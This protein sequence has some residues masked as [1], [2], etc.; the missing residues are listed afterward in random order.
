MD[1]T[2]NTVVQS[3][4]TAASVADDMGNLTNS[5]VEW[6]RLSGEC[7]DLSQ[8]IKERRTKLKA[9]EA[10]I[11]R[12][13]KTHQLGTLELKASKGCL[14]TKETKKQQPLGTKTLKDYL[15]EYMKS[16]EEAITVM[17][18]ITGK[19]GEN[20]TMVSKL[21]FVSLDI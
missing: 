9:L 6:R 19:R 5:I 2:H 4:S 15:A 12:I 13:M 10:V 7:T 20:Q 16:E 1:A 8:Q 11:L 14:T 17:E 21:K 18:F 3:Q